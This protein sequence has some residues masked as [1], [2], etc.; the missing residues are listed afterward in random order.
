MALTDN[1]QKKRIIIIA[2][3]SVILV[4]IVVTV[5]IGFTQKSSKKESTN[6]KK[7]YQISD[8][9]KAIKSICQPT[10]FKQT[11]EKQ[12]RKEAGNS[13]DVK[14]LMQAAFKAGVN[15]A[16]QAAENSATL[17]EVEQDPKSKM[18]LENCK[19]LLTF[20]IYEFQKSISKINELDVVVFNKIYGDLKIWLSA[21]ITNQ[22]TCLDGFQ[23]TMT[24]T[25]GKMEKAL[26]M[27]M[28]LSR[29]GLAIVGE[30]SDAFN[31]LELQG[32]K[33]R[34]LEEREM[35]V[36]G[37]SYWPSMMDKNPW[38]HHLVQEKEAYVIGHANWFTM[39]DENNPLERR[40]LQEKEP[41]VLDRAD[42][43]SMLD[44]ISRK[45]R[46]LQ[47]KEPA[48]LGHID[49]SSMIENRR[50]LQEKEPPVAGHEEPSKML[51]KRPLLQEKEPPIAGHEE[52]SESLDQLPLLEGKEPHVPGDEEPSEM[53]NKQGRKHENELHVAGHEEPSEMLDKRR[54]LQ[55]YE[56]H[57]DGHEE[58]S[59]VLDQQRELQE[60]ELHVAGDE[61]DKRSRLQENKFHVYGH[62]EPSEML[63]KRRRLQENEQVDG[64]EQPLEMLY[65]RR[66][67]KEHINV[68]E[69]LSEMLDKK[70]RL[71][72]KELQVDGHEE[73][74]EMLDKRRRLKEHID[75]HEEPW[76]MLDKRR[77]L[78]EKELQVD[79]HEEPLE[80]LD[81]RRRLKEHI[82]GDKEPSKMLDKRRRLQEKELQVDGHEEPSEMLDKR[83]RLKEH[84]DGHEEPWEM[85]DKK[86][87]LQEK[88]LQVDGHEKPLEMLDKQRRLKEHID[89][90][91]EPGEM[92]DKRRRLQENEL[93]VARHRELF[94]KLDKRRR[95]QKNELH[96]V[97][98]EE[99]SKKL[100]N[101]LRVAGHE[102]PS[103]MLDKRRRLQ[104]NG[105]Q[106]EEPSEMLDNPR[107]HQEKEST[108]AGHEK[109][110]EMLDKPRLLQENEP[111]IAGHEEPSEILDKQ[112]LLQG[113]QSPGSGHKEPPEMLDKRPVLQEKEPYILEHA[114]WSYVVKNDPRKHRIIENDPSNLKPNIVVAKDGSGNF[115]TIKDA[116]SHIPLNAQ[117]PFVIYIK[118][119]TYEENLI[120]SYNMTNVALIGDGKEKTRITGH[121]NAADGINTFNTATVAVNGDFFF[122]K[123]IG[124]ENTAGAIKL[125]AV[126]LMM[127]SDFAVVYNCSI[128]GYQYT[129][130]VHSKRQF[131]RD[132]TI[133][134]T[135]DFVF[136]DAAAVFQNCKFVVRK[137]LKGQQNVITAQGRSDE[138]QPTGIV[139]QN[140]TI[141]ADDE[142]VPFKNEHPTFLGRPWGN[143]SRTII[144]ETFI[145]DL[146]KHEGWAVWDGH[147]GLTTSYYSEYNNHGPG[148]ATTHRVSWPAIKKLSP[149]TALG[150]TPASFFF[151]DDWIKPKGVPYTSGFSNISNEGCNMK[152]S[153]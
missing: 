153:I 122:A 111:P 33:R 126:A 65:K 138:R 101:E 12:L 98:H 13:T 30:L 80:M 68:H 83:R 87:R 31:Q 148:S 74:S 118:E 123:N 4:G 18:A 84:I 110:S 52:P 102:E 28:K 91:E 9:L 21:T 24:V 96:V 67:L 10:D 129:L 49:W 17:R 5:S 85:L 51:N 146:V 44:E 128:D 149:M 143:F 45:H 114:D 124:F 133:S 97:R 37:H 38:K 109:P 145:D 69:E 105:L 78:Q 86:R 139:I 119:G 108:V 3:C 127:I 27:S 141:V 151:G 88:E 47:E 135:I 152:S 131:Y 58:P 29:I 54:R 6:T 42:W 23:N 62:E 147:W 48:L 55:G 2:V 117:K 140:S 14:E 82:D 50:F 7:N 57:V 43:S 137:P 76:E 22:Q 79:G 75:G 34:L 77:R 95:L 106:H 40:L 112:R 136:G 11:C 130:Y 99:P 63:D 8:S 92:L 41:P 134:G 121:L 100:E 72:D 89:R 20:S 90:H 35:H 104:E 107:L 46:L 142:L 94:E 66:R 61:L 25:G 93:H 1:G 60:I 56:L 144:M 53:L 103:E 15:F 71:Q 81:K 120:F 125:Q 150:F 73:P 70:R 116:M 115:N 59:E 39:L 113:K 26:N 32:I 36:L 16:T 19:N 64:H 132:C